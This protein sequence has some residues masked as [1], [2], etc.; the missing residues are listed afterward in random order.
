V[1][2]RFQSGVH[3]FRGIR[4][5]DPP[6]GDLR[7]APPRRAA[8][9][10]HID[11][12]S[13]GPIAVQDLDPL[14][15][16]APGTEHGYYHLAA[17]PSEDCLSLNIWSKDL[18]GAA[19]VLV[20]IHGGG[21][22][23]GSGSAAWYDGTYLADRHGVVV[24]SIN[25]RLGL[26]GNLFLGDHDPAAAN[27]A[28]QDQIAALTW[29][30]DNIGSFGGDPTRI[31]IAGES[32]GAMSVGALMTAP[33]ADGLYARAI[34]QSGHLGPVTSRDS[35]ADATDDVLWRLG[36]D[37]SPHVLDALRG[38][39]LLRIAAV[40]RE[41]APMRVVP[42]VEDG[43]VL[44]IDTVAALRAGCA[45][46]VELL[47]GTTGEEDRLFTM[48]YGSGPLGTLD[49][50]LE[51]ALASDDERAR[52]RQ[53]YAALPGSGA[54][55]KALAASDRLFGSPARAFALAHAGSGGTTFHYEFT[56]R[57]SAGGGQL[58]AA[59]FVDVPFALGTTDAPGVEA[60]LGDDV[61]TSA[62]ARR[63]A[64]D[65]AATWAAF[66]ATG[67][68]SDSGLGSWPRYLPDERSSLVIGG[69]PHVGADLHGDR[70]DFWER[71]ADGAFSDLAR[72]TLRSDGRPSA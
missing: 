48:I 23:T 1:T 39:S 27:L 16:V 72:I 47:I 11:A 38:V 58:G 68:P 22:V 46:G 41:L 13:F 25:Y 20:W 63:L 17:T 40:Q 12:T 31:T 32:A 34:M 30:A 57:S 8:R 50:Y 21:F 66:A 15:R 61:H 43:V 2:G 18:G 33:G 36:V 7:F 5:A 10:E 55:R 53:L 65:M 54:D 49:A 19:P 4:Y 64:S 37:G 45:S 70:W 60:L 9:C 44:P 59:H 6:V 24:V 29:L 62:D 3:V 28:I 26:L 42:L 67:S 51:H 35:A 56:W 14:P 52:A 69:P 71:H